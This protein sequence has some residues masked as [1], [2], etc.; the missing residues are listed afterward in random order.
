MDDAFRLRGKCIT[1]LD[2]LLK[3]KDKS[4][5]VVFLFNFYDCGSC[6]DSGFQLVKR[7]DEII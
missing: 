2:S 4:A 3:G 5:N 1:S 7:M 6:I